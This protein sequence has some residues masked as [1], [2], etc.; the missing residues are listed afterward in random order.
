MSV[1]VATQARARLRLLGGFQLLGADGTP[2]QLTSRRARDRVCGLLW[3]DRPED[4]ARA[5]LR[6]CLFELKAALGDLADEVM[7][8]GR[9]QLIARPDWL[10]SDVAQVRRALAARGEEDYA[11]LS[12]LLSR[13][14][15][16]EGLEIPGLFEDWLDQTRAALEASI[17]AEVVSCLD[18]LEAQGR[19][20]KAR[21]LA[22]AYHRRDPL[23]EAVA[24]AA[25]RAELASGQP[26]AAQR[27]FQAMKRLLFEDLGVAPGAVL[28]RAVAQPSQSPE[29][30]TSSSAPAG[31]AADSRPVLAVLAFDNLSGDPQ[32]A[33]LSDG[34]SEEIQQTVAQ[35]ADLKVIARSS[36]FQ[37]R[38][39]E[40][41]V[42]EVAAQLQATHLLDGSVRH[43][44]AR[45][46]IS[47][48]LVQCDGEIILWADS[49]DGE[50]DDIFALQE[51]IA[52]SVA[53]ALRATLST[54]TPTP[55]QIAP[56]IYV[57]FLKARGIIS[58]GGHLYDDT[59]G[60]AA[61][62]LE[63]VVAAAPDYAPAWEL[64]AKARA[65]VLRSV[66]R[67]TDYAEGRAGVLAATETAL[68][69]DPRRGGAYEALALL[70]PWGAYGAR[71]GLLQ[72][73]LSVAPNDPGVLTDMST[74]CWSV[75]R[76][77]EALAL[78]EHACELNPLMP[79]AHLQVAQML[80]YVGDYEA[81][82]RMHQEIYQ[83]WPRNFPILISLLNF[84]ASL[85]FWDDYR[86]FVGEA[87]QF[88]GWQATY[89][90]ESVRYAT[91]LAST[92][93]A[94]RQE[95]V[96]RYNALVAKSGTV[97][98]N[99]LDGLSMLGLTEEALDLASRASFAHVFDPDGPLPSGSF[100]GTILGP[101]S[102]LNKTPRFIDLCDRLGLC[103][104][105]VHADHWPA[106]VEWT[107]YDFKAEVRRRATP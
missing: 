82:I 97:P 74:F 91:A 60:S 34:V 56:D 48:Q 4:Q 40:K 70:E 64:L 15:L 8:V 23:N 77:H 28:T 24:A 83:R 25:I 29:S 42:R 32:M 71:E 41:A 86:R 9:E 65:L 31:A 26:A 51:R 95:L 102:A 96:A 76:F 88:S 53:Q 81:S 78:A 79:G 7:E 68:R 45:V 12:S 107:P 54:P 57:L 44:G 20:D 75:G 14:P 73:A 101:W 17:A 36:S 49:F 39:P 93:P 105:W 62:L 104:Y 38:G 46:R 3:S 67:G 16:L 37:F 18:R 85:G 47:A 92:D 87:E 61:P 30:R 2:I 80:T 35:G 33:Y 50:L 94:P 72:Q 55:V 1:D 52:R 6:Q 99:Y 58:E 89:L 69:L 27:R 90:R 59:A 11:A 19:W 66:R 13:G 84:A 106:C 63:Q 22:D 5:S 43:N 10:D 103:A 100:P 98:L 21:S